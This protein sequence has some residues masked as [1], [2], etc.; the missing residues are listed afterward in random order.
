VSTTARRVIPHDTPNHSSD[1]RDLLMHK[2][3][4]TPLPARPATSLG[5]SSSVSSSM[6]VHPQSACCRAPPR[7]PHCPRS[8]LLLLLTLPRP[9]PPSPRRV[10]TSALPSQRHRP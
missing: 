4:E 8:H 6:Q 7:H 1:T 10:L 9:T 3:T 2:F 5:R